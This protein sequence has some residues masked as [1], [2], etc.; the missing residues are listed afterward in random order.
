MFEVGDMII[1]GNNGVCRVE[2]VGKVDSAILPKDREYYTLCPHYSKGSKIF[3]PVD[4]QK[5]I[6]R[7]VINKEE[8][9]Q[10]IDTIK[11]VEELWIA[12]EKRREQEYKDAVHK[13]D[14]RELVR[15]I[16][17]IYARKQVR[18]AEGKK[19]TSSD[20]RYFRIAEE[21]LYGELAI[22]FEMTKEGFDKIFN[23]INT[24]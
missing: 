21:N 10:L 12:D 23:Y 24:L 18:L 13:C 3:S 8:A 17:T 9:M 16:K 22:P 2:T 4:N 5:V 7:P 14:C 11:D 19:V 1:Y 6:M 15:I 20:E